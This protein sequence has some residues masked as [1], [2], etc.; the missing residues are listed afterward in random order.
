MG[1]SLEFFCKGLRILLGVLVAALAVPVGMQVIARYTGVIPVY[2]WTEELATFLFVWLVMIG[3]MVA[4]WD[5]THFDVRVM[6]DAKRPLLKFIQ[7]GFVLVMI[8]AFGLMFAWYG[9][10]YVKFG[11]LQKSTMMRANMAITFVSVPIA[12][13]AWAIFALYRLSEAFSVFRTSQRSPS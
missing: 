2:L 9:I 10:E 3:S 13:A 12:G 5:Q 8:A 1:Q 11:L 4:V 6:P 7:D